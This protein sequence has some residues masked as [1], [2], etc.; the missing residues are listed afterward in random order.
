MSNMSSVGK[1]ANCLT[2]SQFASES[3]SESVRLRNVELASQL[4]T[5][6][7]TFT[8]LGHCL[9]PPCGDFILRGETCC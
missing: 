7:V 9:I 3:A 8:L 6:E 1:R 5:V 4:K 2:V